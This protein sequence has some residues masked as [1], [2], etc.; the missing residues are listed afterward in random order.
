MIERARGGEAHTFEWRHLHCDGTAFTAEVT[1]TVMD[2][3]SEEYV[4]GFLRDIT[5]T[6]RCRS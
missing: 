5:S 4:V 6:R 2:L 1:L 3:F